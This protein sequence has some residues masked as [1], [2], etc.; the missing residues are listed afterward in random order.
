MN[1]ASAVLEI[2]DQIPEAQT[3]PRWGGGTTWSSTPECLGCGPPCRMEGEWI[4]LHSAVDVNRLKRRLI[5]F[6][7]NMCIF[8]FFA[9]GVNDFEDLNWKK[10]PYNALQAYFQ[11]KLANV[12]FTTEL[13]SR[14]RGMWDYGESHS[15]LAICIISIMT[16]RKHSLCLTYGDS[17]SRTHKTYR[18]HTCFQV[19]E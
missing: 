1:E 4:C 11:S 16:L 14:L 15:N 3:V 7:S 10:T 13:S 5:D 18:R 6:H 2:S 19:P 9:E 17:F 12:H 8:F